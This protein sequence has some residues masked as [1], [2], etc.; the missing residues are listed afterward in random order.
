M[1]VAPK[2]QHWG[3]IGMSGVGKTYWASRLAGCGFSVIHCDEKLVETLA[4]RT[5]RP[6]RSLPEVGD[7]MQLP[8]TTDFA[9][10][11]EVYI[12]AE[13]IVLE[14]IY[15]AYLLPADATARYLIDMGGS[16]VYLPPALLKQLKECLC[17][18]NLDICEAVYQTML[19]AY[20]ANPLPLIW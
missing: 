6:F 20:L 8:Y 2:K 3:F 5:Q 9:Q 1:T 12:A 18:I 16:V 15:A 14:E 4:H 19:Q 17:I 10:R 11:E 7:W 13:T